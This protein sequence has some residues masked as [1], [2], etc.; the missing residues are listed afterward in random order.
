MLITHEMNEIWFSFIFP[1]WNVLFKMSFIA[2]VVNVFKVFDRRCGWI[3]FMHF[4]FFEEDLN[5]RRDFYMLSW[6]SFQ[7]IPAL[8]ILILVFLHVNIDEF[9]HWLL[10][11]F[12][13]DLWEFSM[14]LW[15]KG[16]FH[17]LET[18]WWKSLLID[19]LH[20]MC[21]CLFYSLLVC[22]ILLIWGGFKEIHNEWKCLNE[23]PH[24]LAKHFWIVHSLCSNYCIC[25]FSL[26]VFL[27][28]CT[29][30]FN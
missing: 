23:F 6:L 27:F 20:M 7:W 28:L 25:V 22:W 12:D 24:V 11:S 14:S 21:F 9:M 3:R 2:G 5:W 30:C 26:W 4:L 15:F 18:P 16:F 29:Y 8:W 1:W 19:S 13:E 17:T 10:F